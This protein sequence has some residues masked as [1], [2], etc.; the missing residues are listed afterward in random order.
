MDQLRSAGRDLDRGDAVVTM[1]R[2]FA[3]HAG[4]PWADVIRLRQLVVTEPLPMSTFLD[5]TVADR[6]VTFA[7]DIAPLLR[8]V[9]GPAG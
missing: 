9:R 5:D 7:T 1:P 4:S 3:E 2:G 6:V 8:F